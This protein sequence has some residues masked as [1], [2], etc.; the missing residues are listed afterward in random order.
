[1]L[2]TIGNCSQLSNF[3]Y[4]FNIN[5]FGKHFLKKIKKPRSVAMVYN[6]EEI[7]FISEV[8]LFLFLCL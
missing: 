1:M 6:M 4:L 3:I 2:S 7:F 8:L 5:L